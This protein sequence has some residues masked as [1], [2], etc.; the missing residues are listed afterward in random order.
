MDILAEFQRSLADG[1]RRLGTTSRRRQH[2]LLALGERSRRLCLL[3]VDESTR[4][5]RNGPR[6]IRDPSRRRGN[7]QHGGF[8]DRTV[9]RPA[10]RC[11]RRNDHRARLRVHTARYHAQVENSRHVRRSQSPRNARYHW[12][13]RRN[14]FHRYRRQ[15]AL[16]R[17][18]LGNF[19]RDSAVECVR[20]RTG[21]TPSARMERR[22][23][24]RTIAKRAS[25]VSTRRSRIDSWY[26]YRGRTLDR[27]SKQKSKRL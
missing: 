18:V 22:G 5:I 1:R 7:R 13:G 12:R 6:A 26:R 9:G 14:D 15:H 16:R 27:Y 23:R 19:S 8:H 10:R 11:I 24:R 20:Q 3:P 4:K 21:A 2:V 25:P 17:N